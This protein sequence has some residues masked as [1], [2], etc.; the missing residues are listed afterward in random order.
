MGKALG[1]AKGCRTAGWEAGEGQRK[2]PPR[3]VRACGKAGGEAMCPGDL[4]TG[5]GAPA[6]LQPPGQRVQLRL[7]PQRRESH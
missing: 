2:R 7:R 6:E 5:R 3:A 4:D 1:G